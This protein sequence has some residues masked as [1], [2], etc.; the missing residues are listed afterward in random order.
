MGFT[1]LFL[2]VF[3]PLQNPFPKLIPDTCSVRARRSK[4]RGVCAFSP[5]ALQS[6]GFLFPVKRHHYSSA[7]LLQGLSNVDEVSQGRCGP[8][9]LQGRRFSQLVAVSFGQKVAL[10]CMTYWPLH[11]EAVTASG[12]EAAGLIYSRTSAMHSKEFRHRYIKIKT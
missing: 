5:P 7:G 9:L 4:E 3:L 2:C 8:S 1:I 12:E 11:T 10:Q 6:S